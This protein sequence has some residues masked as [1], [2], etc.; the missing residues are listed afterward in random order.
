MLKLLSLWFWSPLTSEKIWKPVHTEF[1]RLETAPD[2][3]RA[4]GDASDFLAFFELDPVKL[5]D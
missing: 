1:L 2:I 3:T 4:S 5:S